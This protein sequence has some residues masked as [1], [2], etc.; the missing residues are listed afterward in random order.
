VRLDID[1]TSK[2][3]VTELMAW[4]DGGSV[5]LTCKNAKNEA[6]NI[7]FTQNVIW[8]VPKPSKIPGR[9]YLNEELIEQRSELEN[10]IIKNL[11]NST[12]FERQNLDKRILAE[13]IN[14]VKSDEYLRSTDKVIIYQR[15]PKK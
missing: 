8:E 5:T 12:F 4:M 3:I 1:L 14:Y 15:N 6:F 7:E 9:I 10:L 13:K 11:E 2:I